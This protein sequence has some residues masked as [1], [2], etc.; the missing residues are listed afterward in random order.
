MFLLMTRHREVQVSCNL[1]V[2]HRHLDTQKHEE[3]GRC[4]ADDILKW[5]FSKE[6]MIIL[7]EISL[8]FVH[9]GP[10]NNNSSLAMC[11][12]RLSRNLIIIFNTIVWNV[13]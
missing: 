12:H 4:F 3:Y 1:Y 5:I 13:F 6:N 10:I 2:L 9:D 11:W 7:I 8:K